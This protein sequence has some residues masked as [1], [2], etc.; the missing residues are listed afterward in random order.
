MAEQPRLIA[1][2]PAMN[3]R[4]FLQSLGITTGGL[5]LATQFPRAYA[6]GVNPPGP[7]FQ[8]RAPEPNPKSGGTLR[9]AVH[10]APTHF[11]IHQS[12]TVANMGAQ[13]PMYDNLIR[14]D[15]RDGQ[16]IIPDLAYQWDISADGKIYTF[17]LR[18][19]VKFHDGADFTAE[20]VQATF[21][22]IIWPPKGITMPRQPLFSAVSDIK[23]IDPHTIAF[24]L[25]EPRPSSFMLGAF[26]SGWNVIV[27]KKTLVDNDYN[28]RNIMDF[29]GTGPFKH[30]R[31]VDK[32]VWVMEK[33]RQYWNKGLPYVDRLE[34]Y[35]LPPFSPEL[36]FSP[37]RAL[38]ISL[39]SSHSF[40]SLVHPVCSSAQR[41]I[42]LVHHHHHP[43]PSISFR[44]LP[45]INSKHAC[46][47]RPR[48]RGNPPR[49][50]GRSQQLGSAERCFLLVR[51][52]CR[53]DRPR[54]CRPDLQLQ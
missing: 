40:S 51:L 22:R 5:V 20:D 47:V 39:P 28:L 27:R 9:Y 49:R 3:R 42:S 21:S 24:Q 37:R 8:L 1:S 52:G 4:T 25:S 26:A 23:V 33:N 50:L 46:L 38:R 41:I 13:G 54:L 12:G 45:I 7:E 16:T 6:Q 17:Y 44:S 2:A 14:R 53:P 48:F 31:R 43:I 30:S 18:Q 15:P 32:E 19:G 34:V 29:P 10:S 11:D 36:G 35:H